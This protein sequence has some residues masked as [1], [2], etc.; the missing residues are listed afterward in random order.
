MSYREVF[1]DRL[2]TRRCVVELEETDDASQFL[3]SVDGSTTAVIIAKDLCS[4][5]ETS[6]QVTESVKYGIDCLLSQILNYYK[7]YYHEPQ[8][9][10]LTE[11]VPALSPTPTPPPPTT[12]TTP[13]KA[14]PS[15]IPLIP[16]SASYS[17]FYSYTRTLSQTELSSVDRV[18]SLSSHS[19]YY[20]P[21]SLD[22]EDTSVTPEP[23]VLQ[24]GWS[25]LLS[26][27]L[28]P[29]FS[30]FSSFLSRSP[31]SVLHSRSS[32]STN[33]NQ[34]KLPPSL[35]NLPLFL[36][37]LRRGCLFGDCF[38]NGDLL[39]LHRLLI[40]S[41]SLKDSIR[42]ILPRLI[43]ARD[44]K[45]E[46]ILTHSSHSSVA[47]P[48]PLTHVKRGSGDLIR[49]HR[50][51]NSHL[52]SVASLPVLNHPYGSVSHDITSEV[53]EEEEML[54]QHLQE[55]IR[56]EESD[57]KE[58][59]KYRNTNTEI[60]K[61]EEEK[62]DDYIAFVAEDDEIG[63]EYYLES[64]WLQNSPSANQPE[65]TILSPETVA[66]LSD[67]VVVLD[68]ERE[69]LI[70]IGHDRMNMKNDDV[71]N[72]CLSLALSLTQERNPP[73]VIRVVTEYSSNSRF[74]L[75][76]LIPSH[77]DP[78]DITIKSLPILKNYS[79]SFLKEHYTKFL[80]TDDMSFREYMTMIYHFR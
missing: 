72:H 53:V 24:S 1:T 4:N 45:Q 78:M 70:W 75:C 34:S 26:F 41:A 42:L 3:G 68:T 17:S 8:P 43:V 15:P 9:I 18:D 37:Y 48:P 36:Y 22:V 47:S 33:F 35:R 14:S 28:H 32:S 79:I 56:K 80:Y 11:V 51:G 5:L 54:L 65:F 74:V 29:S 61:R 13:L 2:I 69:I 49:Y 73:S 12:P 10:T 30:L 39:Q 31:S 67:S 16:P 20:H 21:V 40:A 38:H 77:K 71:F 76:N 60:K 50:R 27:I 46:A 64:R 6:K 62:V 52:T 63:N 19:P 55:V 23:P 66:L 58:I 57:C 44:K 59:K 7:I 25:H